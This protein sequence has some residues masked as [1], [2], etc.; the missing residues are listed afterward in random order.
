MSLTCEAMELSNIVE[1][2]SLVSSTIAA[3]VR[4]PSSTSIWEA[5]SLTSLPSVTRKLIPIPK[6]EKSLPNVW[7]R[8]SSSLAVPLTTNSI[9]PTLLRMLETGRFSSDDE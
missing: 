5:L 8:F 3:P 6:P 2:P 4:R 1:I 9:L 7:K